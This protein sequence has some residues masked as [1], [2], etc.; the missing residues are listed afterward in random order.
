MPFLQTIRFL[1]IKAIINYYLKHNYHIFALHR[2][3]NNITYEHAKSLLPL[4]SFFNSQEGWC[5]QS[6]S[7]KATRNWGNIDSAGA[8]ESLTVNYVKRPARAPSLYFGSFAVILCLCPIFSHPGEPWGSNVF[9][10]AGVSRPQ[11]WGRGSGGIQAFSLATCNYRRDL[12]TLILAKFAWVKVCIVWRSDAI[13]QVLV[14]LADSIHQARL[15]DT[16]ISG[17][18][19]LTENS[20]CM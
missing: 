1:T 2:L 6:L 7:I 17:A 8:D 18:G 11:I 19:L 10:I 5:Y 20:L 16:L 9:C 12:W 15:N 14:C 3:S 13:P 4:W